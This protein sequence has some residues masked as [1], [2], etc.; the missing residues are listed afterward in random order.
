MHYDAF[1][2]FFKKWKI[3]IMLTVGISSALLMYMHGETYRYKMFNLT[4]SIYY[5]QKLSIAALILLIVYSL[6]N[7]NYGIFKKLATY[8]FA[9]YFTHL[10]I[11]NLL[12]MK[13]YYA[14]F[15][16][17][18]PLLFFASIL[19]VLIIVLATLLCCYILKKLLG[20]YSRYII[21][22]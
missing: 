15:S 6:E 7:R 13:E 3:P 1:M 9:I 14:F 16:H 21:G 22:S 17:S 8:S 12:P 20:K 18:A 2:A 4:E 5:V 11:Y 10:M 19:H